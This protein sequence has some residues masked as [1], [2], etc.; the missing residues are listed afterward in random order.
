MISYDLRDLTWTIFGYSS[1]TMFF[2]LK[3]ILFLI[4]FV[5]IRKYDSSRGTIGDVNIRIKGPGRIGTVKR[6]ILRL[7]VNVHKGHQCI[8]V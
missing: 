1:L 6:I 2:S 3:T 7:T 5:G 8:R 4:Y